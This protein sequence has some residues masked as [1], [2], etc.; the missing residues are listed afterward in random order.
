MAGSP[1][2]VKVMANNGVLYVRVPAALG[3]ELGL[4]RGSFVVLS[5]IGPG[6]VRLETLDKGVQRVERISKRARQ[7]AAQRRLRGAVRD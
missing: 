2:I 4:V 3:R 7:R 5:D 1:E 6:S